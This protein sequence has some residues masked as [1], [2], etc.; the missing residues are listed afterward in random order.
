MVDGQ[1]INDPSVTGG[2]QGGRVGALA[3]TNN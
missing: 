3:G 2:Q 1:D